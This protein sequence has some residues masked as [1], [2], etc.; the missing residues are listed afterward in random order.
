M[1]FS[2]YQAEVSTMRYGVSLWMRCVKRL[3]IDEFRQFR[4]K[5][6]AEI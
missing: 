3:S 4:Y 6:E 2:A 5:A 1:G